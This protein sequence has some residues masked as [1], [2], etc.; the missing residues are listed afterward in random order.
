MARKEPDRLGMAD[1][2]VRNGSTSLA[3][4]I[5]AGG[6]SL[7]M[8]APKPIMPWGGQTFLQAVAKKMRDAGVAPLFVVLGAHYHQAQ[9]HCRSC[10]A[11]AIYNEHWPL[12][13]FSSLRVGIARV[14]GLHFLPYYGHAA[15]HAVVTGV[16]VALIDQ[17]HI[18]PE[19]FAEVA[20]VSRKFPDKLVIP[21][22][23]GRRGHPFAVP[24]KLLSTL[25]GMP[26]TATARD[27]LRAHAAQQ[28][29]VPV[30]DFGIHFDLDT[31]E[32]MLIAKTRYGI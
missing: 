5:L 31:P 30:S 13:Q 28:L 23:Q 8:G 18:I 1:V 20:R 15:A 2:M 14:P 11:L 24:R 4:L 26:A 16:M 9:F 17:P 3:G 27:F 22:F 10:G 29:L 19:V 21:S 25:M 7:R 6:A 12:G 32:D